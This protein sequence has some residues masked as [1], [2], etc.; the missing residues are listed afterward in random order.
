MAKCAVH[1]VYVYS[2]VA[3]GLVRA[4]TGREGVCAALSALAVFACYATSVEQAKTKLWDPFPYTTCVP[5]VLECEP[6]PLA[7]TAREYAVACAPALLW[8]QSR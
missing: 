7:A 5:C 2:R 4:G 6:D 3:V 8:P 1:V